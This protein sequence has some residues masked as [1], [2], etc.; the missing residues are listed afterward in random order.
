MLHML[1]AFLPGQFKGLGS[2]PSGWLTPMLLGL[3]SGV[4]QGAPCRPSRRF[5]V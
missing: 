2:S 3:A 5:V 1:L 4:L